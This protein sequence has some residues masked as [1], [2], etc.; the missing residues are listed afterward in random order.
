MRRR[1]QF[2]TGWSHSRARFP[3][4]QPLVAVR[5]APFSTWPGKVT[6]MTGTRSLSGN[7]RQRRKIAVAYAMAPEA[8][9]R[10]QMT[11]TD[12]FACL[13]RLPDMVLDFSSPTTVS[14][15]SWAS[16]TLSPGAAAETGPG[17]N[18]AVSGR[19]YRAQSVSGA[20]LPPWPSS[21]TAPFEAGW[22]R[23]RHPQSVL[24]SCP[25]DA[26]APPPRFPGASL[27]EFALPNRLP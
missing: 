14:G 26:A 20:D 27:R 23:A 4:K 19:K 2:R 13:H 17:D 1:T 21:D 12:R 5:V 6:I 3:W 18:G 25:L 22:R 7:S 8:P 24:L 11:A 10:R 15:I 16:R 9:E